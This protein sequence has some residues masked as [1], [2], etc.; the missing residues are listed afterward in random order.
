M[1]PG[2]TFIRD[3]KRDQRFAPDLV[4]NLAKA[5]EAMDHEG[6]DVPDAKA[7]F[8]AIEWVIAQPDTIEKR[9][10]AI[11]RLLALGKVEN[12]RMREFYYGLQ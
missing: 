5:L 2:D 9:L 4:K 10:E 8:S 1:S 12:L 7:I 3:L 11:S 6:D